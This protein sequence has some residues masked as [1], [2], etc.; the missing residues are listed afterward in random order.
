MAASAYTATP[1]QASLRISTTSEDANVVLYT[2][3][4]FIWINS[5]S[6]VD[7]S[8]SYLPIPGA[9]LEAIPPM[10]FWFI[11]LCLRQDQG[12]LTLSYVTPTDSSACS[13][14]FTWRISNGG[15]KG[16]AVKVRIWTPEGVSIA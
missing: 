16:L 14:Q 13:R 15:R 9:N 1:H 3:A 6:T 2:A 4:D 10:H 5:Q 11:P 8:W 7:W 12:D